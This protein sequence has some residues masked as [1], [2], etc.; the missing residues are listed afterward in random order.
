ML[1]KPSGI[2]LI[3]FDQ[4]PVSQTAWYHK[5]QATLTDVTAFVRRKLWS[6]RCSV[7]ALAQHQSTEFNLGRVNQL[8]G[9]LSQAA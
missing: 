2:Q 6:V 8:L 7:D 1:D 9:C 5:E 4:L 3:G